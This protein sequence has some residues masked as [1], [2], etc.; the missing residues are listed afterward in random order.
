MTRAR[1]TIN[2]NG[3]T[4][5]GGDEIAAMREA[6]NLAARTLDFITPRVAEGMTTGDIDRLC[7]NFIVEHDA[8]P[9]TLDYKGYPKSCCTSVNHV[10]CHG[11]PSDDKVLRRGDIV[12]VDVTVILDGWHGDTSRMFYIGEPSVLARRL[13][14]CAYESM[15]RAIEILR[16][17]ATL[18]DIGHA[19]Q[20]R[21]E[22]ERFSVVREFCGHGLGREF[23][24][25]PN[26]LHYGEAGAG[27]GLQGGQCFTVEPE[28]D[29]G[30][31]GGERPRAERTAGARGRF[32]MG[33]VDGSGGRIGSGV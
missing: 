10:I 24:M 18:G 27:Q 4:L 17:G 8:V 2:A 33:D 12:N 3:V 5:L 32:L 31:G 21:A 29:A 26:V 16:P 14:V 22:S 15:M 19:I 28:R 25:P 30:V 11:I 20:T 7:H 6:G 9:A 13:T 23:H 1:G